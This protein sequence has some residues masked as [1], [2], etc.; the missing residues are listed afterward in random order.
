MV[1]GLIMRML[2]LAKPQAA[3]VLLAIFALTTMSLHIARADDQTA[4]ENAYY[5]MVT[6]SHPKHVVLEPGGL[7]VL[8]DGRVAAALRKGEIWFIDGA[9]SD[10]PK[11][12]NIVPLKQLKFTRF[13]AGLHE[14]LGLLEHNDSLYVAQR[15]ELTRIIDT[16]NDDRAD[17]Y[18]TVAKGWGVSG[19]YHE[20]CFGPKLDRHGNLFVALNINIG[21]P[22]PPDRPGSKPNYLWRGWSMKVTPKGKL[23][24][25]SAGMRSPSGLGA[26][27]EGDM[28]Y[29]DQQG[30]WFGACPLM[31]IETGDFHGHADSLQWTKRKDSPV[32][33]PGK[34]PGDLTWAQAPKKVPGLKAP[35]VWF[36]YEKA[37]RG[38][39]DIVCDLTG[40]RFGP[41]EKQLF[42]GDFTLSMIVRV[43]LEKVD[44]QY[45]GACFRFREGFQSAVFR[46]AFGK[47]GSMFVGETNRGWNSVGTRSYGLQRLVWTGKT[48][49]EIKAM[50]AKPDGFELAFTLPVNKQTA[51]QPGKYLMS[52]YTYKYSKSYGSPEVDK[53]TL[54]VKKAIVSDDGLRVRLV[55]DGLRAGYVHELNASALRAVTGESLLHADGYYTLNRIPKK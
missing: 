4:R 11:G 35:A 50:R 38:N 32:K 26:N 44:G 5:R 21:Q 6:L 46:M 8:K 25:V 1:R 55:C 33:H 7:A 53:K 24:P 36:P 52:S 27:A 43:F 37:G 14:P 12:S 39:T 20:Y 19:N 2:V 54:T 28:F 10:P 15:S 29:T 40:G 23:L 49:F 13:A 41:F 34:L 16:D 22:L 45:Q 17:E 48:P 31:H 47:D 51:A 9:Y 18:R 3:M 30:N 42:V